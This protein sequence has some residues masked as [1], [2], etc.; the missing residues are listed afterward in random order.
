MPFSSKQAIGLLT[1]LITFTFLSQELFSAKASP[2]SPKMQ[3]PQGI[4]MFKRVSNHLFEIRSVIFSFGEEDIL[5]Q[6]IKYLLKV[7][8][9][10][11]KE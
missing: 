11:L 4:H 8:S 6:A 5:P 9:V 1:F 3:K 7:I 10:T 2:A